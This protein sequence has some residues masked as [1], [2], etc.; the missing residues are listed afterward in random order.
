MFEATIELADANNIAIVL[1]ESPMNAAFY[2]AAFESDPEGFLACRRLIGDYLILLSETHPN[3]FS[4][5]L[6]DYEL[7]NNLEEEG[8]YDA[9]HLRPGA[10]ELV[11]DALIPEIESA[12]A[13]SLENSKK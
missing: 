13:W 8:F 2:K 1:Y 11:V 7:V 10:A 4:R 5:D 3:V 6:S 12:M 9:V